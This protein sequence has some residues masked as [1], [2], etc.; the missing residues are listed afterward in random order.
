MGIKRG[1]YETAHYKHTRRA[2]HS[3]DHVRIYVV[4]NYDTG[5]A[6]LL[7]KGDNMARKLLKVIR[8]KDGTRVFVYDDGTTQTGK[9]V[10]TWGITKETLNEF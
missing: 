10:A 7:S 9:V 4:T 2:T 5:C 8:K 3:S 6:W 1:K